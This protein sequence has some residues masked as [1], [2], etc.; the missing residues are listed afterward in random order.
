MGKIKSK[1]KG[2][3]AEREVAELLR[4]YGFTARRGVQFSGGSDS[5]DV[6]SDL[7][8]H[9][10]VKRVEAFNLYN[11]VDQAKRDCNSNEYVIFHRKNKR[12]WVSI[13]DSDMFLT[14]MEN[15]KDLLKLLEDQEKEIKRLENIEEKYNAFTK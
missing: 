12:E 9:I 5:P 15:F 13:L 11:A 6:V 2:N 8:L 1:Q 7:P 3:Q 4:N 10:E 14:M